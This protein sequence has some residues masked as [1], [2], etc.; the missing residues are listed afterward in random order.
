MYTARVISCIGLLMPLM[1][2]AA[3][4]NFSLL[5]DATDNHEVVY[6]FAHGLG[7]TQEQAYPFMPTTDKSEWII[8]KPVA[9]FDFPDAKENNLTY[10]HSK[11][12][13]GQEIDMERLHSAYEKIVEQ[14][15][16]AT[17]VLVGISRGAV[18][19]LN[20]VA[21]YKPKAVRAIIIE[22]PFDC[23]ANVAN[24]LLN[25]FHIGWIPFSKSIC[26][27]LIRRHFPLLDVNGICPLKTVPELDHSIS[28]FI[29]HART[30][31]TIPIN[32]SRNLYKILLQNGHPNCYFLE[33]A[34]GEHA[35]LLQGHESH[36]I[37]KLTH[38]FY[39]RVGLPHIAQLASHADHLLASY[40][41]PSLTEINERMRKRVRTL[42]LEEEFE[43]LLA[44]EDAMVLDQVSVAC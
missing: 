32:S 43:L 17:V 12:N 16:S 25:R 26:L 29:I 27:R 9:L 19:I 41:Q 2:G 34:S 28:L 33:L 30:D 6:L 21:L 40:C 4:P 35:K 5:A 20:Y 37:Y 10:E 42:P 44:Q 31:R 1:A 8:N 7:A 36:L 24:H 23:F 22:S 39:K 14:Y 13:L 3:E 38:A 18:T 15:P 11:V